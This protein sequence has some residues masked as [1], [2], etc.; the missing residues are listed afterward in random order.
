MVDV[1]AIRES[2]AQT[3]QSTRVVIRCFGGGK[4]SQET[5][6][7]ALSLLC[8]LLDLLYRVKDQ[9][10]WAEEKWIVEASRLNALHELL[11]WFDTTLRSIE[12]YFQ[13]GGI[14]VRYF[15]K[16][17]LEQTFIPRLEQYKILLILSMQP[18]S[19]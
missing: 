11:V 15:R 18:D 4:D 8:D 17:L 14:G 7:R 3:T 5:S 2:L 19:E 12:L 9:L 6:Q 13:P 16:Y 1:A 10:S